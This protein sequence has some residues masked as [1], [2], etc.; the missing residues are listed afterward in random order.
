M[1]QRPSL[2]S[3]IRPNTDALFQELQGE[4]VLLNLKTGIYFGLDSTGTR[5]WQ[6]LQEHERI[7]N[8]VTAMMAEFEVTE[9]RCQE[10]LLDF[11]AEM[12]M[13]GLLIVGLDLS[14]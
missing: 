13:N 5:V 14:K 12:E 4:A 3:R 8:I 1:P 2:D 10:D 9:E 7:S 11:V 6:L